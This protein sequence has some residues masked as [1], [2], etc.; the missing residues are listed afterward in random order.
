[1]DWIRDGSGFHSWDLDR[2]FKYEPRSTTVLRIKDDKAVRWSLDTQEDWAEWI[3]MNC[4][5]PRDPGSGLVVL[6]AR[7]S[8]ESAKSE[9]KQEKRL[10]GIEVKLPVR[11]ETIQNPAP[12][13]LGIDSHR[14]DQPGNL[15]PGMRRGLRTMP[16]SR[17]T[18]EMITKAFY[19]HSSISRVISRADIPIFSHTGAVMED[20]Q[21]SKHKASIFNCRTSNAWSMDLALTVTYFPHCNLKFAVVFGCDMLVEEEILN[22]LILAGNDTS[23]PLL[24]A[25]IVTEIERRRHVHIVDDIVDEVEARIFQLEVRPDAENGLTATEME[26]LHQEKRSAWLNITYIRNC[27][28]SWRQQLENLI[29]QVEELDRLLPPGYKWLDNSSAPVSHAPGGHPITSETQNANLTQAV[30]TLLC[31]AS[32]LSQHRQLVDEYLTTGYK[33]KSRIRAIIEE[34]DDKIRDCSLRIDGMAM[35]TQWAQGE[36]NVEIAK[37]TSRDSK[38]MRSIA[39]VTMVFLPGTFFAGVFSMTFFDWSND[40]GKPAV[41]GYLWIYLVVTLFFTLITVGL[42]YYFNIYRRAGSKFKEQGV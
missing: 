18:F 19:M 38:H 42:W 4:P 31:P 12:L 41:S 20:K 8:G 17:S 28:V 35:A 6:F 33:V 9:A 36:T 2:V 23:H 24:L 16:F 7:R 22:R 29:L 21:G 37:A 32:S 5:S 40:G 39:F 15:S 11:A 10:M 13:D 14:H 1:M 25:G 3:E 34:Y 27:L 30:P 26:K